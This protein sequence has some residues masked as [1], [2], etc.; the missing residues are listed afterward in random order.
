MNIR[1]GPGTNYEV[2]G[3]AYNGDELSII[4]ESI[5]QGSSSGWGKIDG[6]KGWIALDYVDKSE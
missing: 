2:V 5:G 4:A 1:Q 3:N 6:D